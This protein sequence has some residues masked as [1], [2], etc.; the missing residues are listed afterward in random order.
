[1]N[2][3]APLIDQTDLMIAP[4]SILI[5]PQMYWLYYGNI[6]SQLIITSTVMTMGRKMIPPY[7]CMPHQLLKNNFPPHSSPSLLNIL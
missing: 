2:I 6:T 3:C 4:M 7:Y 5:S 1:M